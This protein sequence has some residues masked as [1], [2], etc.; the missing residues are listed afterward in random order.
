VPKSDVIKDI[1]SKIEEEVTGVQHE[2]DELEKRM[3]RIHQRRILNS[4][5]RGENSDVVNM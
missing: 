4:I 1:I 3:E 2:I 5:R